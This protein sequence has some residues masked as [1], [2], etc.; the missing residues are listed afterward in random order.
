MSEDIDPTN[1]DAIFWSLAYRSNPIEDVHIVPYRS[2]G[3]GP[4]SGRGASDSTLLIDAT[5]KH[6]MPPLALPAR[7]F[8]ERAREHLGGARPA[9]ARR[10]SRR[11]T[12][13]RSATGR[14]PGTTYAAR[15]VAGEWETSGRET[16][17]RAAA[18]SRRKRRC[19]RW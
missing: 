13:I 14:T 10:R 9:G 2:S 18:A 6:A 12:A 4:K 1:A 19:A 16:F 17:A 11:G 7:E 8:M 3:H 5:L 15:A